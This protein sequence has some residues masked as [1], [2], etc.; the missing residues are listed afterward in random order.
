MFFRNDTLSENEQRKYD[1]I[2]FT[3]LHNNPFALSYDKIINSDLAPY[4]EDLKPYFANV[5]FDYDFNDEPYKD[6]DDLISFVPFN[7]ILNRIDF[8]DPLYEIVC[9]YVYEQV[10]DNDYDLKYFVDTMVTGRRLTPDKIIEELDELKKVAYTKKLLWI[11]KKIEAKF[12][13]DEVE[14]ESREGEDDNF[15]PFMIDDIIQH[16]PLS[17]S[18]YKLQRWGASDKLV[19]WFYE[20]FSCSDMLFNIAYDRLYSEKRYQELNELIKIIETNVINSKNKKYS[21]LYMFIAPLLDFY[22]AWN[23]KSEPLTYNIVDLLKLT[24][25]LQTE[26]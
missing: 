4:A 15:I 16:T 20:N 12:S 7:I 26:I 5:F 23:D 19:A 3:V 22:D 6:Y 8:Y 25:Y 17:V 14:N 11:N 13:E 10:K 9:C 24:L 2:A 21:A 1:D 18:Q